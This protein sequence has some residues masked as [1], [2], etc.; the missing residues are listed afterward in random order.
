ME[1]SE[2]QSSHILN[3]KGQGRINVKSQFS[4]ADSTFDI[5]PTSKWLK[6]FCPSLLI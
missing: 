2:W 5:Y 1:K 3:Y 6:W 4:I